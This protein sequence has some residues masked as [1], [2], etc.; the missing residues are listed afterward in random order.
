MSSI[1]YISD[2]KM[3]EYHRS[4]GNRHIN[5]WRLSIKK[6]ERFGDG[7]L[8]FFIDKRHVHPQ[9]KE[10]G[11]IGYGRARKIRTMSVKRTWTE[12][13][14]MNG[15]QSYQLYKEA[16]LNISKDNVIPKQIQSIELDHVVFF[17]G[18]VYLSEVDFELTR[19][20]E[21]FTYLRNNVAQEFL[22]KSDRIG[23][24]SWF[25]LMNQNIEINLIYEDIQEQKI[26]NVLSKINIDWTY[27]QEMLLNN[28]EDIQKIGPLG[29]RYNEMKSDIY[30]PCSSLK[31]QYYEI[32]GI[33]TWIKKE[34][35]DFK[36]NAYVVM[37]NTGSHDDQQKYLK[38][39]NLMPLY[40]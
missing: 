14:E 1:A 26:R 20:L 21:S 2:E 28:I 17:K 39:S 19:N 37:R 9:T 22:E 23:I 18:P 34:L 15:Y 31:N 13:E 36:F 5:F 29:Y 10:K 7:D 30:I 11:I 4:C 38:S 24:D 12:Y 40:I 27:Q 33:A 25:A 32:L 8:L 35:E 16:I 6:F 3:L